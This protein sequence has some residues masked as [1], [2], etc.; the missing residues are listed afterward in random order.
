[1]ALVLT[2][3]QV[4]AAEG[5]GETT[6]NLIRNGGFENPDVA[7]AELFSAGQTMGAWRVVDGSVDLLDDTY[8]PG[9]LTQHIDLAGVEDGTIVQ[10][11]STLPG[12]SYL[13]RFNLAASPDLGCPPDK[14]VVVRF[15][16]REVARLT[17]SSH[18]RTVDNLGWTPTQFRVYATSTASTLMFESR[19]ED[20]VCGALIDSGRCGQS[21]DFAYESA[22]G[23]AMRMI[24][25]VV[26]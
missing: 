1:M 5:T 17:V 20:T 4:G 18:G 7:F 26:A 6:S 16:G 11:V 22:E 8:W 24:P 23:R 3:S 14:M 21:L 2:A 9:G 12:S 19:T 13:L 10:R 25:S 15:G